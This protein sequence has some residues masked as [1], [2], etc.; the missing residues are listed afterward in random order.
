MFT[1]SETDGVQVAPFFSNLGCFSEPGPLLLSFNPFTP[2]FQ[3]EYGG[4]KK[5]HDDKC[6]HP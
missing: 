6:D 1:F 3:H 4:K 5:N 2:V